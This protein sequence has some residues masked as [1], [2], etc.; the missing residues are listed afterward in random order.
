MCSILNI[1]YWVMEK[2]VPTVIDKVQLSSINLLEKPTS[3][4]Y[5][6]KPN[7]LNGMGVGCMGWGWW[8]GD[9]D[10]GC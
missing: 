4:N 6:P 10:H 9:G 2:V 3:L 8:G 7:N 5:T 1:D